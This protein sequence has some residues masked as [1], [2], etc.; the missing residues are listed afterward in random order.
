MENTMEFE[1][2]SEWGYVDPGT[3]V[4]DTK[5]NQYIVEPQNKAGFICIRNISGGE[6]QTFESLDAI[7]HNEFRLV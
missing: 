6:N 4:A 1:K 7:D 3:K 5:G 2:I